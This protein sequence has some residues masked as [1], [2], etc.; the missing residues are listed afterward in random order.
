MSDWQPGDLALCIK[1]GGW[2]MEEGGPMSMHGP[3]MGET[4][5]VIDVDR[6]AAFDELEAEAYLVFEE[7]LGEAWLATRFIKVS[8]CEA[9]ADDREVIALLTSEP[10]QVPA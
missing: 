2:Q 5:V 1:S 4:Y 3:G 10:N 6:A 7:W 8:G 9:D